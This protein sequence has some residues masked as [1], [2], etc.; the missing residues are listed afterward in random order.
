MGIYY[1]QVTVHLE[2][3]GTSLNKVHIFKY[4]SGKYV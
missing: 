2:F 1:A 4:L 3:G